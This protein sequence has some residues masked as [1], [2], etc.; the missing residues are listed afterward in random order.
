M[1]D[2]VNVESS[3]EQYRAKYAVERI[4]LPF[5]SRVEM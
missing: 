1:L 2:K 5:E 3:V 4:T